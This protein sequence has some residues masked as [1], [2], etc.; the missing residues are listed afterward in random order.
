VTATTAGAIVAVD[1]RHPFPDPWWDLRTGD[2]AER[3]S[4][5]TI[6]AELVRELTAGHP[7]HGHTLT[8]QARCQACDDVAVQLA[9]GAWALVHLTWSGK[10]ET[11]P[12]PRTTFYDTVD[13]LQ[14]DL[15]HD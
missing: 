9:D 14:H 7:L 15:D 5:E 11:P 2:A 3:G 8:V 1:D 13:A 4:R 6:R 10:T 12:W